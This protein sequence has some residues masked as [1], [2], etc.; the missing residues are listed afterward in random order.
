MGDSSPPPV[1]DGTPDASAEFS[2]IEAAYERSDLPPPTKRSGFI[3]PLGMDDF[4]WFTHNI[5]ERAGI[6]VELMQTAVDPAGEP[7]EKYMAVQIVDKY[8][9]DEALDVTDL[10]KIKYVSPEDMLGVQIM[11]NGEHKWK[12]TVVEENKEMHEA[13]NSS[14]R[15]RASR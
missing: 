4:D 14:G 11:L 9:L 2:V 6:T 7:E 15:S 10:D 5:L 8:D 1:G 3:N 13:P 12:V